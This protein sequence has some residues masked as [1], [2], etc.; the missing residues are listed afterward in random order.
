MTKALLTLALAISSISLHA[1][2]VRDWTLSNGTIFAATFKEVKGDVAVLVAEKDKR[3]GRI[4]IKNL[5]VA[6]RYYL[7]TD[8]EIPIEDLEG[9]DYLTFER[10]VKI[11]SSKFKKISG[12][13]LKGDGYDV[14]LDGFVTDH[15]LVLHEKGAKPQLFAEELERAFISHSYRHPDHTKL[16]SDKR[17]A[18][19]FLKDTDLYNDLG[20]AYVENLRATGSKTNKQINQIEVNWSQYPGHN[21]WELPEEYQKEFNAKP[22]VDIEFAGKKQ[23][24]RKQQIIGFYNSRWAWFWPHRQGIHSRTPGGSEQHIK[25]KKQNSIAWSALLALSFNNDIRTHEY[26]HQ[27]TGAGLDQTG[28]HTL[29]R[30]GESKKWGTEI[31]KLVKSGDVDADFSIFYNAPSNDETDTS[32]DAYRN[33]GLL[34]AAAGRFMEHD[35][36]HSF[37]VCELCEFM[38]KNKSLPKLDA[39]PALFGYDSLDEMNDAFEEFILKE[40]VRMKP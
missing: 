6:D 30:Y 3:E 18:Y 14:T 2:Q 23:K 36:E 8:H 15:Y 38:Q 31:A 16:W 7:H 20:K 9:G 21:P 19:L 26:H 32:E 35:L 17:Q 24:D 4:P 34:I 33:F 12:V 1:N 22:R 29:G 5:G 10:D 37:G 11:D 28:K 39:F 27:G 25:D 40:N 13:K